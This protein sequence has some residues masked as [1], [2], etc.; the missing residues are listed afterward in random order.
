M[1]NRV[2]GAEHYSL[3]VAGI[4]IVSNVPIQFTHSA[5]SD[6]RPAVLSVTPR[7]LDWAGWPERSLAFAC[8]LRCRRAVNSAF[9][10]CGPS[11]SQIS[12]GLAKHMAP[13]TASVAE[14]T[15]KTH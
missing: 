3:M 7:S 8:S 13:D 9:I 11:A 2:L 6:F 15:N 12:V 4:S 14:V 10:L 5:L 1:G